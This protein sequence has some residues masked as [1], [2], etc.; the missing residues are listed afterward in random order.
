MGRTLADIRARAQRAHFGIEVIDLRIKRADLPAANEQAVF[1]RMQSN[2]E[3]QA[4]QN[5]AMGQQQ[6]LAIMADADRQVTVTLA[7]AT[8]DAFKTRGAGDAQAARIFAGSF[9]RDARFAAFYR[10]LQ[11]YE[12]AFADGQ[13]TLVLSP[14]SDFFKYFKR[15]PG[16]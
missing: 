2:M 16:R 13:T 10:S 11:A 4:A 14:D 15:G 12:G 6:K 3:Q 1:R 7:Q 9:G 8:A 5:R